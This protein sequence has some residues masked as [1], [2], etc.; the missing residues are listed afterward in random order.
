MTPPTRFTDRLDAGRHLAP[1]LAHLR[2]SR[3]IVVGIPRGGVIVGEPIAAALGAPLDVVIVRKVGLPWHPEFAIGALAEDG[4]L[5][6]DRATEQRARVSEEQ[7]QAVLVRERAEVGRRMKQYRGGRLLDVRGRSAIL[8]DDGLATGK[9]AHAAILALRHLG[10]A[11]VVLAVPVASNE[12][13]ELLRPTVDE[14]VAL[15]VP[16]NLAA[17]GEWYDAFGDVTDAEVMAAI[18]RSRE[19]PASRALDDA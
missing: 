4:T 10:A 19:E 5:I 8:V 17:V 7:V 18:T 3:P 15:L 14:L 9:T 16:P 12:A 11:R 13:I 2:D 6:R 1:H